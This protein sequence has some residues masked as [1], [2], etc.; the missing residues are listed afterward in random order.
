MHIRF[1]ESTDFFIP[2]NVV[3]MLLRG[4]WGST[5]P[6]S[7]EKLEFQASESE[8]SISTVRGKDCKHLG[9]ACN[10]LGSSLERVSKQLRKS[11]HVACVARC[12]LAAFPPA[13]GL[14]FVLLL[15]CFPGAPGLLSCFT[16]AV[17]A[18]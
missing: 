18:V 2:R 1:I 5:S 16:A 17:F 13:S 9:K 4:E 15:A 10:Q 12:M 6:S 14:F 8:R 7:L 3:A 11:V